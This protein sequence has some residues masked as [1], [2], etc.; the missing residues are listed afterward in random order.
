VTAT[1]ALTLRRGKRALTLPYRVG[2]TGDNSW[3]KSRHAIL[4]GFNPGGGLNPKVFLLYGLIGD[5][6]DGA[7]DASLTLRRGKRALTVGG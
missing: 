7:P 1:K 6:Y 3:S 4:Q 2:G 5:L